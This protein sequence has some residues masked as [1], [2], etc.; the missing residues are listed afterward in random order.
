[1]CIRDRLLP[2]GRDHNQPPL[3][4]L[5]NEELVPFRERRDELVRVAETAAIVD[6]DSAAKT[7][8]LAQL[9]KL[10]EDD[11]DDRRKQL[12]EPHRQ[13]QKLI[14]DAHNQLRLDVQIVRQG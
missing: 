10:F 14:N 11:I 1:M 9:C 13:A 3:A 8:D 5:L 6:D 2:V 4:E 12:A 7:L